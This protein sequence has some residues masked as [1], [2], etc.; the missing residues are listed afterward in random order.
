VIELAHI[1]T[2]GVKVYVPVVVLLTI[3]GFQLPVIPS[4]DVV[5]N[6]GAVVLA[7]KV[8]SNENVGT[9]AIVEDTITVNVV[10]KAQELGFVGI[11]V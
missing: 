9:I 8:V 10:D 1:P 11:K 2:E 3:A 4:L 6:I 7:H 5:G